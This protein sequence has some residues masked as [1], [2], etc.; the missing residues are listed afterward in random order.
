MSNKYRPEGCTDLVGLRFL[1]PEDGT[2]EGNYQSTLEVMAHNYPVYALAP[3]LLEALQASV[4]AMRR[5]DARLLK[6]TNSPKECEKGE[7]VRAESAIAKATG[8]A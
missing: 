2:E 8:K 1:N 7:I 3:E 6:L 5:M 4:S